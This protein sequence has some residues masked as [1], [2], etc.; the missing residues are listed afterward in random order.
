VTVSSRDP[1]ANSISTVA[2]NPVLSM[3]PSRTT[4]LNP[5]SMYLTLY[6]PGSRA[7]MRYCPS[8]LV[9]AERTRSMREGLWASTVTPGNTAPVVS[10][11]V[12]PICC[13]VAGLE[14]S[15]RQAPIPTA[16]TTQDDTELM[17]SSA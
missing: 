1:I 9:V 4:V 10:L 15:S 7:T 5:G 12:P 8:T 13:A 6:V 14:K 2:V 16:V 3:M 17:G 11:T